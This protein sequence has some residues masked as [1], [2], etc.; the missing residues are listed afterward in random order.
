MPK[1][2]IP[3]LHGIFTDNKIAVLPKGEPF[4]E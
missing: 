1:Y 3:G 4:T 2:E